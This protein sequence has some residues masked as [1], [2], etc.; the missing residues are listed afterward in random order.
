MTRRVE[1]RVNLVL[2]VAPFEEGRL[3]ERHVVNLLWGEA[4]ARRKRVGNTGGR[5][6]GETAFEIRDALLGVVLGHKQMVL[7]APA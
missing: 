6:A 5:A 2:V 7:T 1:K 4:I 3:G